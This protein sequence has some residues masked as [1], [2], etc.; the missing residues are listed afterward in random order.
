MSGI[1]RFIKRVCVQTA[2]YWKPVGNDGYGASIY[3]QPV[4][5]KVRWEGVSEK[6]TENDGEEF[7]SRARI[8]VQQDLEF[9]GY[10]YL[11]GIQDLSIKERYDPRIVENAYEIKRT[12]KIPLFRA[13]DKFVREVYL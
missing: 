12:S 10:L 11:G 7:I 6:I 9:K 2:I 13:T 8:L 1:S 3:S 4:E 5:I